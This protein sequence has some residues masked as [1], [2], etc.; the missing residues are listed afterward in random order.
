M[1]NTYKEQDFMLQSCDCLSTSSAPGANTKFFCQSALARARFR[2]PERETHMPST[3]TKGEVTLGHVIRYR[4]FR[5][6]MI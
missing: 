2:E 5:T 3:P 4:V 6:E 1:P